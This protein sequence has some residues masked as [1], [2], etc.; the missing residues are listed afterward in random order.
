MIGHGVK[1]LCFNKE[2]AH[3]RP[4]PYFLIGIATLPGP[5]LFIGM[6]GMPLM[7]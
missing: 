6:V 7:Y 2:N 5:Y 1:T 3:D 4:K